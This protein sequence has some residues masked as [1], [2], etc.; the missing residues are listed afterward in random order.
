MDGGGDNQRAVRFLRSQEQRQRLQAHRLRRVVPY[1]IG[2]VPLAAP[3]PAAANPA[4]G[5]STAAANRPA[6]VPALGHP[7]PANAV[8]AGEYF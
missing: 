7:D 6:P 8:Q 2:G 1:N 4:A 3:E 5:P